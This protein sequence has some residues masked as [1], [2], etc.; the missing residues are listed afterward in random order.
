MWPKLNFPPINLWNVPYMFKE[1]TIIDKILDE[2]LRFY[3]RMGK[4]ASVVYLGS[5]QY[6]ELAKF[7]PHYRPDNVDYNKTVNGLYIIRVEQEDYLRVG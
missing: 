4:Y 6:I 5:N 7:L 3:I 1:R 2:E